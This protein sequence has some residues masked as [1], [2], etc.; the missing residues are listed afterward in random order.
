MKDTH[1]DLHN[2]YRINLLQV[3]VDQVV[4]TVIK[5]GRIALENRFT[6]GYW[7]WELPHF[8]V[9]WHEAFKYFQEI[10]VLSS[11]MQNTLSTIS[12]VPVVTMPPAI[13]IQSL[14]KPSYPRSYFSIPEGKF[15]FLFM[16]DFHSFFARKNPDGVI[17]AFCRAFSTQED[18]V[19]VIK[20]L[21][22]KD[23][24]EEMELL[25][26]MAAE[27]NVVLFDHVY[28]R[29]EMNALMYHAD[30]Y[31]SLHRSEGFGLTMAEAMSFGKPVIA[32]A[33][34]GNL[35]FMN[36]NNS[37]LVQYEPVEL[38][39]DYGPYKKGNVWAEPDL[40]HAAR[41]MRY[42]YENQPEAKAIGEKGRS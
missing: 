10:W 14:E 21:H 29:E 20:S 13:E 26:Q 34:S 31:V 35:D 1:F 11:F 36:A 22:S 7:A 17:K 4:N 41:L 38:E 2:P 28:T 3:N 24:P 30:C 8:P 32:T 25:S 37:Y 19:L 40:E 42:V 23:Y 18:V 33:Y 16:F 27:G 15:V 6:I 9:V 39:Q 5:T 12:P